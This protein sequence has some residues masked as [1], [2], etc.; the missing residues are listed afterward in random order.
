MSSDWDVYVENVRLWFIAKILGPLSEDIVRV[1]AQLEAAG[2]GHL[3]SRFPAT[4]S[5]ASKAL[6]SEAT[7]LASPGSR[8]R[9]HFFLGPSGGVGKITTLMDL[10]QARTASDPLVKDRLRIERYL[11]SASLSSQRIALIKRIG[12]LAQGASIIS[13][14]GSGSGD[15]DDLQVSRLSQMLLLILGRSCYICFVPSWMKFCPL[16]T[17]MILSPSARPSLSPLGKR[18]AV[19]EM[20]SKS[21]KSA[22][23]R[24]LYN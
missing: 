7:G 6:D 23:S 10:V 9:S 12:A 13:S 5:M 16:K 4:Y 1:D 21:S 24:L 3:A 8:L 17:P 14:S 19:G 15:Q 22:P 11:S 20:P 2:L 18:R